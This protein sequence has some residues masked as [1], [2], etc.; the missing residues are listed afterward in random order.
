MIDPTFLLA[1]VGAVL[2][3]ASI[4]LHVVAPRTRTTIDD[5]LRDDIDEVLAFIRGQQPSRPLRST[6]PPTPPTLP[7][8]A[9]MFLG[10]LVTGP[11]M[12]SCGA[13]KS[14]SEAAKTAMIDCLKA[15]ATAI[16]GVLA[17]LGTAAT[18]AALSH[19][20]IDWTGIESAS[21]AQGKVVGGCALAE[22]VA[23]LGKAPTTSPSPEQSPVA[24]LL[25]PPDPVSDGR[26]TLE[27]FR[28]RAGG[29]SWS[30][31]AGVL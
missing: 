16:A 7:T 13:V 29:V 12:L 17:E 15:D 21:W 4:I 27:R 14:S 20:A 18:L 6:P 28:V 25:A 2:A 22:F 8:V 3:A 31:S 30:T 11:M 23:A 1:L 19:G 10:V 24:S 9:L 26:A 5:A